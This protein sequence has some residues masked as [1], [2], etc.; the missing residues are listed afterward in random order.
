MKTSVREFDDYDPALVKADSHISINDN[1]FYVHLVEYPMSF[2][3]KK[4]ILID[5]KLSGN[6]LRATYDRDEI[7]LPK[8]EF[9]VHEA[10][11]VFYYELEKIKKCLSYEN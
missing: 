9:D 6:A 4:G 8:N 7:I 11:E 1:N 3:V 2:I 10:I 5:K